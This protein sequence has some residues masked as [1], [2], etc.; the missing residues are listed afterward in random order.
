MDEAMS[1]ELRIASNLDLRGLSCPLP[2]FKLSQAVKTIAVGE[3]IAAAATDGAVVSD[4]PAWCKT[5]GNELVKMERVKEE[6]RFVVR[7]VK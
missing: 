7:R 4:I 5:T 1:D 3:G 2:V 6:F